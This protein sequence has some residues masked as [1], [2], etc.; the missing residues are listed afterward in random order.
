MLTLKRENGFSGVE[1]LFVTVFLFAM[2]ILMTR[3][4]QENNKQVVVVKEAPNEPAPEQV[5]SPTPSGQRF[6][7]VSMIEAI[8]KAESLDDVSLQLEFFFKQYDMT[9]LAKDIQHSS[10]VNQ[11]A[12]IKELGVNDLDSY[13]KL[14]AQIVDEWAKYPQS[15]TKSVEVKGLSIVK[16]VAVEG[17]IRAAMPDVEGD[18]VYYAIDYPADYMSTV[19]HHELNHL[20]EF[21]IHNTYDRADA[22][23][24]DCHR[25]NFE[26][27]GGGVLAY[28]D[29]SYREQDH[30]EPGFVST[31]ATYAIEEDK[32]DLYAY[33]MSDTYYPQ[34][35]EWAKS[36][37]C[38]AEK[39]DE[40]KDFIDDY[41]PEM[42]GDY[43]KLVNQ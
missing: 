13:K 23:W 31:Y 27:K 30:P 28:D 3:I 15:W 9:Y 33:L 26:Y 1:L 42:S 17:Q 5:P 8:Q 12:A 11:Y 25:P 38:L 10:Y 39:I 35:L 6:A 2:G 37:S 22:E 16:Q 32:A 29:P 41:S 24:V 43:F 19:I 20:I 40:Y 4:Y 36:D 18:V 21:N 34:I 7:D 14:A